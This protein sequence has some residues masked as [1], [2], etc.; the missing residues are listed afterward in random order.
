MENMTV[1]RYLT[2]RLQE[3]GLQHIFSV[4]EEYVLD[5]MDRIDW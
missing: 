3:I 5:F 1:G 2:H 4:P